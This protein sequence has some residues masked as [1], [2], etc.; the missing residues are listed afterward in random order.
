[1]ADY[2][3]RLETQLVA[4]TER[5]AHRRRRP[6]IALPTRRFG[7]E[8]VAVAASVLVVVV[9]AAVI[10]SSGTARHPSHHQPPAS[11]TSAP[12]VLLNQY[13]SRLPA[14]PG[15]FICESPL[16]APHGVRPAH[17][18]V[19]FYSAPPTSTEM[20]LTAAGLRKL[21]AR[22]LY[23]VW[24]FPA[25]STV[26]GGYVLQSS[27]RPQ[28]LGVIEPPVGHGGHVAIAHLLSQSFN[29]AYKLVITV[30]RH[31]S[32]RAPGAVVLGGFILF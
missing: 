30:Q 25:V 24:V 3:D 5:G 15:R 18:M 26:S 29:G 1:M 20:F 19:R 11:H 22:D 32:L 4:L 28:L 17:G 9:V 2:Y 7:F 8:L 31:G 16:H 21:S 14:P 23:A 12:R 27:H 10:F 6:R 13:P